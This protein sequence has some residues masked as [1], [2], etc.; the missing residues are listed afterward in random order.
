MLWKEGTR[1]KKQKDGNR[2]KENV[3]GEK[4]WR[5]KFNPTATLEGHSSEQCISLKLSIAFCNCLKWGWTVGNGAELSLPSWG[6]DLY[7]L[8]LRVFGSYLA[9]RKAN[10]SFFHRF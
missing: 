6:P 9:C 7:S 5:E 8:K 10:C 2:E 3:T 1:N 4:A